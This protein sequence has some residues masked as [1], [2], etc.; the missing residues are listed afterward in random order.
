MKPGIFRLLLSTLV[1][2][3]HYSS[4]N[5]GGAAVYLF[6]ALSGY[7]I[8]KM[9]EVKYSKMRNPIPTFIISRVWRLAPVFLFCSML[10]LLIVGLLPHLFPTAH[11]PAK[12]TTRILVSSFILLGYHANPHGPLGPAWSLD[13]EMQY[14][15]LAPVLLVALRKRPLIMASLLVVLG[16]ASSVIYNNALITT[17]LPMFLI[18]MLVALH[19]EYL[20][21]RKKIIG[22][23]VLVITIFLF[24]TIIPDLRKVLFGG[25]HPH[26]LFA[27]NDLLNVSI[28]LAAMPFAMSTVVHK[29]SKLD[30]LFSDLSYSVYLFHWIP[31][32]I[33]AYYFPWLTNQAFAVRAVEVAGILVFTYVAS[34]AITLWISR[35]L[36]N[37][38]PIFMQN[39]MVTI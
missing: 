2:I 15:L 16:C 24:F 26:D 17:Y 9:W 14:Y 22:S 21:S 4:L 34:L 25:A 33:V 5:V 11:S 10:A 8:S 3:T 38:R 30:K 6:F 35:P 37:A 19:P 36:M 12:L 23:V 7:W 39:S 31:I 27:F 13:M 32:L 20:A 29:S 1:V 28:A 18:G